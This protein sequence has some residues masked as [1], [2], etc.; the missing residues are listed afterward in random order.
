MNQSDRE[1]LLT[2]NADD[3][4]HPSVAVDILIFTAEIPG[5]PKLLLIQRDNP[6]FEGK[7][8]LPGGFIGLDESLEDSARRK[9]K[10]ETGLDHIPIEQ[11]YTFGD[12]NRD[13]RT[14]VISVAYFALVPQKLLRPA[15][16]ASA[17]T[18]TWAELTLPQDGAWDQLQVGDGLELAF[19]HN[20]MIAAAL[21]RL[22]GKLSYTDIAFELL[23]DKKRFTIYELQKI[24]E[25][26]LNQKLDTP[27]F[28]RMFLTTYVEKGKAETTGEEC[29][30]YS[31]RASRYYRLL[32]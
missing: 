28:R 24:Y 23:E 26:I 27:N 1:F 5:K 18:T 32:P 12:V 14:R 21:Q 9:L 31:R 10:E 20:R 8:A 30:Q 4:E 3:Y 13:P 6:P 2:Y 11:L 16:E 29:T 15:A 25:A 7:W 22:R 17:K 19:D